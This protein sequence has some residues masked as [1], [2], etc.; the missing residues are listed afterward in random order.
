MNLSCKGILTVALATAFYVLAGA[1]ALKP[2]TSPLPAAPGTGPSYSFILLGDTHFDAEPSVYHS[3]LKEPKDFQKAEFARN[4][5]MWTNRNPRL[6]AAAAKK[7]GPDTAFAIQL[8]DLVQGD[9]ENP[10]TH[11]KMLTDA[12]T[13]IKKSL[14]GIPFI[15]VCGNHDIRGKGAKNAYRQTM[16]PLIAKELKQDIPATTFSFMHGPDLYIFV[17][18]NDPKPSV[19]REAFKQHGDARYTF[20]VTHGPAIPARDSSARNG[21]FCSKKTDGLR[22]ELLGLLLRHNAVVLT[23]HLHE[24]NY[25]QIATEEGTVSQ[26]LCSSVWKDPRQSVPYVYDDSPAKYD[27]FAAK[28][29]DTNTVVF[30]NE[31]KPA[32]RQ[33]WRADGAGYAVVTVSPKGVTADFFGG[34]SIT[35]AKTFTLR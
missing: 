15:P 27:A 12:F 11:A 14:G 6:L 22:R 20:L 18:F 19:I 13:T 29:N 4:Y 33:F 5:G 25:L 9:C 17:D 23:G 2:R 1:D 16:P 8:G 26:F 21:L 3:E 7:V 24:I 28:N 34:D 10:A 35:P 30:L 31:Y 32:L